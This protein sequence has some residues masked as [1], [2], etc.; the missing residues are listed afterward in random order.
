MRIYCTECEAKATI[1]S[2][3][4]L[5]TTTRKAYCVCT[6]PACGHSFVVTISF[7]HTISPSAL[8]LPRM[9]RDAI[10]EQSPAQIRELFLPGA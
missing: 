1:R 5:S 10:Q 3:E 4:Q 6:N 7:S 2:S 8:S 9:L